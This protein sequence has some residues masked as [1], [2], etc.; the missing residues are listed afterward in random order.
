MGRNVVTFHKV[1]FKRYVNF[2]IIG[3]LVYEHDR[4]DSS[5]V[6]NYL[7]CISI[8]ECVCQYQKALHVVVL[9]RKTRHKFSNESEMPPVTLPR[10]SRRSTDTF[11]TFP[12]RFWC[13]ITRYIIERGFNFYE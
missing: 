10:S 4:A 11:A 9:L 13:P 1:Y 3:N 5:N 12:E 6:D 2:K 8:E 7:R